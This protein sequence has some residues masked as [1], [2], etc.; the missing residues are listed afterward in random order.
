VKGSEGRGVYGCTPAKRRIVSMFDRGINQGKRRHW[1]SVLA[2][3]SLEELE[4]ELERLFEKP[5]YDLLRQ[6][7]TGIV[8]VRGR[9]GGSGMRFNLGEMTV[10]RCAVKTGKGHVGTAYVMGRDHRRAELAALFDAI[11]QDYWPDMHRLESVIHPLEESIAE[12]KRR[13]SRAS[14][15]T[16]VDFFTMV[17]GE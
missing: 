14:A 5:D 10:S 13:V 12:K 4:K 2:K 16:K 7:E 11:F 17:R 1:M 6:P 3:S 15:A 9:A 8:M